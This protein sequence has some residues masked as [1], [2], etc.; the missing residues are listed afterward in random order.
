MLIKSL[1]DIDYKGILMLKNLSVRAKLLLG[2]GFIL[3]IIFLNSLIILNGLSN[4]KKSANLVANESVPFSI[5]ASNLK[6]QT[7]EV[8]Q[9]LTDASATKNEGSLQEAQNSAQI[10]KQDLNKFRTMFKNENDEKALKEVDDVEKI[11][12][13]YYSTGVK[14]AHTYIKDGTESGNVIMED[15]D[16]VA[17]QIHGRVDKILNSQTDEA[18]SSSSGTLEITNSLVVITLIMGFAGLIIGVL[19]GVLLSKNINNSLNAFQTGLMSFF[20]FL[21]RETSS[22]KLIEISNNDEFGKMA[23]IINQNIIKTEKAIEEDRLL[24]A[25]TV[26]VLS[27]FEHG[28]LCQRLNMEVSNPALREL[29]NVLN[30]MAS[31]LEDHIDSILK[32][33]EQYS[34]YNYLNKVDTKGLKEHLLK[35]SNGVNSLGDSITSMLKENKSN[36]LTLENSS[37]KLLNSVKT[38][39]VSSNEAAASLEQTSAALEEITGNIRNSTDNISKMAILANSVT[40]SATEGEKLA[41]ET[42]VS[43]EE[44]NSQVQSI[45]E[46]ITVID[47]IAFQTNILSLNAAVEAATAGEAGKGFAVVAAEVRNLATR[48]AEA[49]KEIKNIVE[50]AT[51]KANFGKEISEKMIKGYAELNQ[52]INATINLI[53]DIRHASKEQLIGIEQINDAVGNLDRQTQQNAAI[54]LSTQEVAI[55]TD[56]IAQ[57]V[58]TDANS[59]EFEG[60]NN[61]QGKKLS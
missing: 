12:D 10:F 29:K 17:T 4:I 23:H 26:A 52:N 15:F 1:L 8:Q 48:S 31:N 7:C 61:I 33:L 18:V 13:A 55:L 20:S 46:A 56:K 36:G 6:L 14:M 53:A 5:T 25:Q 38:L 34:S 42:T 3:G 58:V 60:K 19:I 35:L 24:I 45:S 54:S 49:A 2:I 21:N 47:Q 39:S 11:F 59:K 9:F 43:M 40:S 50:R 41:K 30:N 32:I 51:A 27:E 16:K 37:N 28:D 44:I 22:A 57:L